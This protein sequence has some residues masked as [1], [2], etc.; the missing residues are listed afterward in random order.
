MKT[1]VSL[2]FLSRFD[3][4]QMATWTH[5]NALLR[6]S[7][8]SRRAI[9]SDLASCRASHAVSRLFLK[10]TSIYIFNILRDLPISLGE[11][12]SL[13]HVYFPLSLSQCLQSEQYCPR[14]ERFCISWPL[15]CDQFAPHKSNVSVYDTSSNMFHVSFA[16]KAFSICPEWEFCSA[17]RM[18]HFLNLVALLPSALLP[19]FS[20]HCSAPIAV[21]YFISTLC[22]LY[23]CCAS[24]LRL[25]PLGLDSC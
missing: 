19:K 1:R 9:F 21:H 6:S 17:P 18:G 10:N 5:M 14:I 12:L 13:S 22:F 24:F 3:S 25:V 20:H 16:K 15:R 23:V 7:L 8:L 2:F 4:A 11:I